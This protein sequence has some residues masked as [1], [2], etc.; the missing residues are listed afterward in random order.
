ME[1][2]IGWN[3]ELLWQKKQ[4]NLSKVKWWKED[5]KKKIRWWWWWRFDD[6]VN[7][8]INIIDPQRI[9]L[10]IIKSKSN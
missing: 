3:I 10:I 8:F 2:T 4:E 9:R 1:T 6:N 5:E 7:D